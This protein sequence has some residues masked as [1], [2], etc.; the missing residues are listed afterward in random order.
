M[1]MKEEW[2]KRAREDAYHY[3]SCFRKEWDDESFYEWGEIQTQT[4]IDKF[5][6]ANNIDPTAF[7]V[8]EIGCGA[9]RISRALASRFKLVFAYDISDEY[10]RIAKEKNNHL[11]NVIFTVNNGVSFPEVGDGS[12]DFVFSGWTMQHMPTK[13]VVVKNIGEIARVLKNGGLYKIDPAVSAHSG[14]VETVISK[15]VSSRVVRFCASLLGMDELVVT[16]TWRGA[17]FAEREISEVL[18][19]NG[20]TVKTVV[21]DDGLERFHGKKVMRKWFYGKKVET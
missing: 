8:L 11:K 14:L 7:V 21:E 3:V 5:F 16:P 19:R 1:N 12:I 6:E 9:G 10:I 20:L 2:N 17:R 15:A 4:V 13:D 18:F